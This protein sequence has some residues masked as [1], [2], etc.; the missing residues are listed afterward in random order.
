MVIMRQNVITILVTFTDL[1]ALHRYRPDHGD[2]TVNVEPK[3]TM[4]GI[5]DRFDRIGLNGWKI[6]DV[7]ICVY[8]RKRSVFECSCACISRVGD[9][10]KQILHHSFP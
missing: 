4:F 9:F 5:L 3:Y 10:P 8:I 2:G 7:F 6:F 1:H